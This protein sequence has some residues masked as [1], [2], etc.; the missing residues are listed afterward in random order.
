MVTFIYR[1]VS[2]LMDSFE[3]FKFSLALEA[4]GCEVIIVQKGDRT[5]YH[6]FED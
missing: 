4:S 6:V 3:A 1:G 5:I 2:E